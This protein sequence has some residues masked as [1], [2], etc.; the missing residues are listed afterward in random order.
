[1]ADIKPKPAFSIRDRIKSF[2]Y[3]KDGLGYFLKTQH[4]GWIQLTAAM[5][6]ISAGFVFQVNGY[7]WCLLIFAIALVIVSELFNTT[8]ECLVDLVSPQYQEKARVIK[9]IAAGAVLFSVI[10]SV[11]IGLIIFLPKI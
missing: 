1:M 2:L 10:I 4:N 8:I 7:E 6:V 5:V 9:D 3:A 11:I